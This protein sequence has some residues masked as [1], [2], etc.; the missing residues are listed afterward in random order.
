MSGISRFLDHALRVLALLLTLALLASVVIGVAMRAINHPVAWSDEAAQYLLVWTGFTGWMIAARRNSHIRITMLQG[1]LPDALRRVGETIV[2][3][4]LVGF[5]LALI[6]WG[7]PLIGR[8]WDIDWVSLPLSAG[9][10]YLPV[11]FVALVVSAQALLAIG[12]VW[13]GET[14][15]E[16]EAGGQPL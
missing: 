11:P 13:R 4:A 2:Q 7:W 10:L 1:F 5:C 8:N 9:L 3:L 16:P 15:D 6:W 12:Q 14:F